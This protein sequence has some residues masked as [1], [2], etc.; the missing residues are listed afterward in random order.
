HEGR[1]R[2]LERIS[3]PGA[4]SFIFEDGS[5]VPPETAERLELLATFL[6]AEGEE[7]EI[8]I[9]ELGDIVSVLPAMPCDFASKAE[10]V[11]WRLQHILP[12]LCPDL[13]P[14]QQEHVA[15]WFRRFLNSIDACDKWGEV[16]VDDEYVMC[17]GNPVINWKTGYSTIVRHLQVK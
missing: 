14:Q 6:L 4:A 2:F 12:V 5:L 3:F 7:D 13:S 1:R 16:P 11:D 8:E 10:E 15:S 17:P 9:Q